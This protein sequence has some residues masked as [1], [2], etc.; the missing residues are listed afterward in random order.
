MTSL[1]RSKLLLVIEVKKLDDWREFLL[2]N[3]V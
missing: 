1:T 2:F 3:E